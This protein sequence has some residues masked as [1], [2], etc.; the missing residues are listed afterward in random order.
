MSSTRFRGDCD[1]RKEAA[2]LGRASNALA[3]KHE[4][5]IDGRPFV[6][7]SLQDMTELQATGGDQSLEGAVRRVLA[8]VLD[9]GD[10]SL[11]SPRTGSELALREPAARSR[12]T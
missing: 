12:L 4:V 3:G 7:R 1:P 11:R 10:T 8:P 9:A 5:E 6:R 2:Q